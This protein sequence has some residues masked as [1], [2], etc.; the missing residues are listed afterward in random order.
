VFIRSSV[1]SAEKVIEEQQFDLALL[2]VNVTNGHSFEV[3]KTLR[4]KD[5]PFSF[6]SGTP[7]QELPEELRNAPFIPKPFRPAQIRDVVI[8]AKE[9]KDASTNDNAR[10]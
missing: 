7:R 6:V 5:V 4:R 10:R 1:A 2:D 9:K 8:K 3:A